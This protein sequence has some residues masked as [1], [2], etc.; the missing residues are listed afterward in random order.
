MFLS[1]VVDYCKL[2]VD[3][4]SLQQK[5]D[6]IIQS[7]CDEEIDHELQTFSVMLEVQKGYFSNHF[8]I[9]SRTPL[10]IILT[11][12]AE[13][14]MVKAFSNGPSLARESGQIFIGD[15]LQS[16]NDCPIFSTADAKQHIT[17]VGEY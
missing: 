16:V 12:T 9:N 1:I 11:P 7:G 5:I 10:G 17:S 4:R 14:V 2:L 3:E 8:S 6:T 13:G 15:K